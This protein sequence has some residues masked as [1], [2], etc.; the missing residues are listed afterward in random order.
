M[1]GPERRSLP[2]YGRYG[3]YVAAHCGIRCFLFGLNIRFQ[4]AVMS[5]NDTIQLLRT[6]VLG[7]LRKTAEVSTVVSCLRAVARR[8]MWIDELLFR[9]AVG[10]EQ[11]RDT[12]TAR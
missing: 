9:Y 5:E 7:V 2:L 8:Q 11:S 1:G 4:H 6:G 10:G 12:L 3:I